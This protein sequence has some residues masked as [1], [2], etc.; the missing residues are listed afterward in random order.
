MRF[1]LALFVLWLAACA[2]THLGSVPYYPYNL[3]DFP[4]FTSPAG[5]PLYG[6]RR[7]EER[8][9]T[10]VAHRPPGAF[11]FS[12]ILE[13]GH[14]RWPRPPFSNPVDA[15]R[16]A[17]GE[18]QPASIRVVLLEAPPGFGVGL[19]EANYKLSC[20]RLERDPE[21]F[22]VLRYATWL[23]VLYRFE[24]PP[25]APGTY[26]LRW[27]LWEGER[28]VAEEDRRFTLTADR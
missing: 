27:Q 5:Q 1:T 16:F 21:G 25:V 12:I 2:P 6:W 4:I 18:A 17:R 9:W 28:L 13:L 15:C 20:G 3:D 22:E 8:R 26:G 7:Y 14:P 24:I 19:Q 11:D 10:A 23:E